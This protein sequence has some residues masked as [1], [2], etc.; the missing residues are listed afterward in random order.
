M[1]TKTYSSK[2]GLELAIPLGLVLGSIS[3][4]MIL[5]RIWPGVFILLAVVAFIVYLFLNTRYTIR[6]GKLEVTAGFLYQS[7]IDVGAIRQIR[8][9]RNP[10]SSPALSLDRLEIVYNRYDG[11]LLSPKD[12]QGFVNDLLELNP[13]IE[14]KYRNQQGD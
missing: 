3:I 10:L 13:A 7:T 12:K 11:V 8:E 14:V 4:L 2:I 1:M 9:T 5:N 6:N